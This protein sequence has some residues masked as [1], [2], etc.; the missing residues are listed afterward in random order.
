MPTE[1]RPPASTVANAPRAALARLLDGNRR[2][3]D[4]MPQHPHQSATHRHLLA[5]GQQPFAAVMGCSDSRASVEL[6]LDQGFGD[7]FVIRNAGHVLGRGGSAQASVE[8]AVAELGVQVVLILG[9]ESCGAVAATVGH[10]RDGG[11]LPGAMQILADLTRH[12]LDPEDPA[13]D[14]VE[15][16]VRGTAR[17]L[18]AESEIVAHAV[19]EGRTMVA[20]GVYGLADGRVRM[21]TGA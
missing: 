11:V 19:T 15:R 3:A 5:Q 20:G 12:H 13:R 16:H 7:V 1:S 18:L 9:H 2:F 8:Y 17:D 4:G 21:V 6:L 14:A 10:M